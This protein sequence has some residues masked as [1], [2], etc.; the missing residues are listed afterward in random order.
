MPSYKELQQADRL[1]DAIQSGQVVVMVTPS[2]FAL[3][4]EG[5]RMIL[6]RLAPS[7]ID[8][9]HLSVGGTTQ[10]LAAIIAEGLR[11]MDDDQYSSFTVGDLDLSLAYGKENGLNVLTLLTPAE[12]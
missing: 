11:V 1:H 10:P 3:V 4:K 6:N 7:D 8:A 5:D 9:L 12:Y 2:V